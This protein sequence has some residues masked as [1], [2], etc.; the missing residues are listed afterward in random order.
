MENINFKNDFK[1]ILKNNLDNNKVKYNNCEDL[2]KFMIMYYDEMKRIPIIDVNYNVYISDELKSKMSNLPQKTQECIEDISIRLKEGKSITTYLSKL[3]LQAYTQDNQLQ[4]WGIYHAHVAEVS[5]NYEKPAKRSDLVL[6]FIIKGNNIYFIDVKNH[7]KNETW[8]DKSL[9]EI[10]YNNWRNL[11]R[12][13]EKVKW[14]KQSTPDDEV[15]DVSK[16]AIVPIEIQG[17]MV[18]PINMGNT[19]TGNSVCSTDWADD[20]YEELK[21][22]EQVIKNNY[23]TI[24]DSLGVNAKSLNINLVECS[25]GKI[26]IGGFRCVISFDDGVNTIILKE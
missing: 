22:Y 1:Q 16:L 23:Q 13:D 25:N 10:I 7:P 17:N 26:D 14:F 5:K 19:T 8:F 21:N 18:L 11:L 3:A 4:N 2:K 24:I 15:Q 20:C 9:I 12:I 6:F